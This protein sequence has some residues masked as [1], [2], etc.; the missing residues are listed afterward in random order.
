[1]AAA[2]AAAPV[3]APCLKRHLL[4]AST[5]RHRRPGA[6]TTSSSTTATATATAAVVR[7]WRLGCSLSP[8]CCWDPDSCA[9]RVAAATAAAAAAVVVAA[10]AAAAARLTAAS[11]HAAATAAATTAAAATVAATALLCYLRA[12][13]RHWW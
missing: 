2:T 6:D 8:Q 12:W 7:A 4:N 9:L 11:F 1:V 3:V 10:T 13:L 5:L